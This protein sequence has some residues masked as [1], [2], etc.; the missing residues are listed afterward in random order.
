M[1]T[2]Y[3][4]A[5]LW[6]LLLA[7]FILAVTHT[8]SPDHWVPFVMVG[9]A[10]RWRT[11]VVLGLAG[12]AGMG[13]VGTSVAIGLIGV[14]AEQGAS[15]EIATLFE[16][17]TPLLLMIFGFGYT[18]YAL[19]KRVL[20]K[21]G[22]SHGIPLINKLLGIDPH[23]YALPGRDHPHDISHEV[24]RGLRF[25]RVD[26]Y[27]HNM[28]LHIRVGHDDHSH[29]F[30]ATK[31]NDH[32]HE[33]AHA[34][35]VHQHAHDHHLAGDHTR[36]PEGL[37]DQRSKVDI[38]RG[39]AGW[40]LVAILGLTPCIAL[41]PLTFAAV[42]YGTTPIILVN[43]TFALATIGTIVLLTWLGVKGLSRIKLEF[44]DE[45]GDIIAGVVIGLLGVISKVFE[46]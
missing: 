36:E 37:E 20:G 5:G 13:H 1:E 9:R 2:T 35:V 30:D 42:R 12:L 6:A 38:G 8:V 39:K 29:H 43:A 21:H 32:G 28:N 46:L 40:G 16:N 11:S 45:Y 7:T 44:F 41:L 23:A 10:K 15:R 17:A 18:A 14:F 3:S 22:H 26:L 4:Q 19:Y 25:G 24:K 34:Q 33:H 31:D 27:L